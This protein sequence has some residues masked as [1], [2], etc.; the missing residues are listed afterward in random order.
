MAADDDVPA[1][2]TMKPA[3]RPSARAKGVWTACGLVALLAVLL[4]VAFMPRQQHGMKPGAKVTQTL[5]VPRDATGEPEMLTFR[6]VSPE[7]AVEL[8]AKIPVA[9]GANPSA[10]AFR[11]S[12]SG[13]NAIDRLN[14]V[15]CLTAAIYYEGASE[16]PQGQRAIAQVVLNRVRHPA[17]P[18]TVCGVVFQGSERATGCQFTFTCDG[19]MTR[20][21]SAAGWQRAR[22]YAQ[23]ALAGYVERSVGWATHY[24]TIWVVPYWSGNLAKIG[25]I[26]SHIFYRWEGGWGRPPAFSGRYAGVEMQPPALAS[27]LGTFLL[28]GGI[29]DGAIPTEAP[30]EASTGL[31]E[32]PGL[33]VAESP[34]PTKAPLAT[35]TS[36]RPMLRADE[37]RGELIR[38]AQPLGSGQGA[39]AK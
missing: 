23:D 27:S 35:D 3:R 36:L 39:S 34:L 33:P 20:V 16:T 29:E 8:N 15:D 10:S 6:P 13:T 30:Q 21:P 38:Q 25:T 5:D 14:A 22:R 19:A 12:I 4:G 17:Y 31:V 1:I 37:N 32:T 9:P 11:L 18:K 28:A 2:R 24:H 26:G 7:T